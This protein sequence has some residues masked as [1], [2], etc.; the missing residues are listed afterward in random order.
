LARR[1]SAKGFESKGWQGSDVLDN[2]SLV[3]RTQALGE[4]DGSRHQSYEASP[5]ASRND[6]GTTRSVFPYPDAL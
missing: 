6:P 2:I 5:R 4:A 3:F 1:S